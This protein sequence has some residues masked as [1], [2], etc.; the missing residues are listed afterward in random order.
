M[1]DLL[2]K[3]WSVRSLERAW[4]V[5][6]QN[7]RTSKSEEI[8]KEI[9][10]FREEHSSKLKSLSGKLSGG[11]FTFTAA[12]GV[13]LPK[14]GS[15]KK[16]GVKDFR[17]IVIASVENR[18]VQRS[19]LNALLE[20]RPLEKYIHT[21]HSFG[22]IRKKSEDSLAAV[23]AAIQAVLSSIQA[24]ANFVICADISKFFTRIPKPAVSTIVAEAVQDSDFMKLF[25]RAIAVELSN[26]AELREKA[27]AFPIH[28]IGVAQGNSLSPLL[29]NI[30]LYDFDQQMNDGDCDSI[31]YIDDVIMLAPTKRAAKS[32]LRK[33]EIILQRFGMT[34]G[35]EKTSSEPTPATSGFEFL[36]IEL[37]NGLIRPS[38]KAQRKFVTSL[39]GTLSESKKAFFAS[40]HGNPVKKE[41]SLISTLRRVDGIIQGWGKHY[42]FCNDSTVMK[43]LDVSISELIRS[44]LGAYSDNIKAADETLRRSALGIEMLS[45]LERK[46]LQ[47]LKQRSMDK[48]A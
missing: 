35:A 10:T 29:G 4:R 27:D 13:A 16:P 40:R 36:G 11:S 1:S 12:K 2:K 14:N 5:I 47:W 48:A 8:K 26:L 28:D 22:G 37:N 30:L 7:S 39:E 15:G 18:I 34:F 31:R 9:E 45:L 24:G 6:D 32:R 3:V 33:A 23:P 43:N 42:R 44:Y 25:E 46:P 19:I 21:P 38:L 20:V 41:R 17:P